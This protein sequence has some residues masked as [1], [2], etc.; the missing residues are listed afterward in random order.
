VSG[1]ERRYAWVVGEQGGSWSLRPDGA[2]QRPAW[3]Q[4]GRAKKPGCEGFD[5]VEA[6]GQRGTGGGKGLL[7]AWGCTGGQSEWP[8][9]KD[10]LR[11]VTREGN[12][13]LLAVAALARPGPKAGGH[14][15]NRFTERMC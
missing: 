7:G 5:W 4:V 1:G 12:L 11:E 9:P 13:G 3:N 6:M 2:G 10:Q 8:W 15:S 14:G